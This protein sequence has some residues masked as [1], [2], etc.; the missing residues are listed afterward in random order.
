MVRITRET[1]H[2]E[3]PFGILDWAAILMAF[4]LIFAVCSGTRDVISAIEETKGKESLACLK[5]SQELQCNPFSPSE[6]CKEL[7]QCATDGRQS[8]WEEIWIVL[9]TAFKEL[10]KQSLVPAALIGLTLLFQ[11]RNHI[12]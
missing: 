1:F 2:Q 3:T 5:Q 7:I 4:L 8:I 6:A 9:I 12:R 11:L 10:Q